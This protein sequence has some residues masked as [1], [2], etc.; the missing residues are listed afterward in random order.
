MMLN[1]Y[2]TLANVIVLNFEMIN[3]KQG[4]GPIASY[5]L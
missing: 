1:I 3:R 5:I 4:V 2:Q